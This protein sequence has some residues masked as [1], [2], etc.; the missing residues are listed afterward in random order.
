MEAQLRRPSPAPAAARPRVT[1]SERAQTTCATSSSAG[2]VTSTR[3]RLR[4]DLMSVTSSSLA[5][6]TVGA[7]LAP[8]PQSLDGSLRR[9]LREGIGGNEAERAGLRRDR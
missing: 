7:L 3:G 5:T 2:T 9:R 1:T 6:T 4:N 8:A